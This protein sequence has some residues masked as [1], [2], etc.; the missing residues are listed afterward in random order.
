MIFRLK[1][2]IAQSYHADTFVGLFLILFGY[3]LGV[4]AQDYA[5]IDYIESAIGAWVHPA[6]VVYCIIAGVI[7][8]IYNV[9]WWALF[10]AVSPFFVYV[11]MAMYG[12]LTGEIVGLTPLRILYLWAI[13][14]MLWGYVTVKA[15]V[16]LE[17]VNEKTS[18]L[19]A[20]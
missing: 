7:I 12:A 17:K 5:V 15:E 6:I 11:F 16:E 3:V 2:F 19:Y 4:S 8:L 1:K 18:R 14:S 13:L 20:A 9:S 10:M